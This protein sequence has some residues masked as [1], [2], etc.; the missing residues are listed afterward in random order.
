MKIIL[1]IQEDKSAKRPHQ[2]FLNI[3][4]VDTQLETSYP[5]AVKETGKAKVE[6]VIVSLGCALMGRN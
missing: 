6:L 3:K 1:A 5:L 4:D 2:A